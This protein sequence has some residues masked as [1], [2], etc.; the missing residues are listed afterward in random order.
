ML[1]ICPHARISTILWPR[2][3]GRRKRKGGREKPEGEADG[4]IDMMRNLM[5]YL[6]SV[7]FAVLMPRLF[8][9]VTVRRRWKCSQQSTSINNL[10]MGI[11]RRFGFCPSFINRQYIFCRLPH[12]GCWTLLPLRGQTCF[13]LNW[14]SCCGQLEGVREEKQK[15]KKGWKKCQT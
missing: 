12:S 13:F 9:S 6:R 5:V 8:A 11:P 2:L 4:W 7:Q 15:K 10:E 3:C 1:R 14:I